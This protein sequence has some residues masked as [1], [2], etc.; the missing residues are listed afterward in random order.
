MKVTGGITQKSMKQFTLEL[1]RIEKAVDKTMADRMREAIINIHR[2]AQIF[3]T[4]VLGGLKQSIRMTPQASEPAVFSTAPYSPYVEFG[5]GGKV[6]V[7]Q[8]LISFARQFKGKGIKQINLPA[9][10]FFYPAVFI[11]GEAFLKFWRT[12][13]P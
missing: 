9:R 8:D 6:T 7:P 3:A 2:R 13:A 1:N 5:T 4:V 10:P 12:Y 11:E